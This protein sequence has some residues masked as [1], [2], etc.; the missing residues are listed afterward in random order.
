MTD[1]TDRPTDLDRPRGRNRVP[2]VA[3]IALGVVVLVVLAVVIVNNRDDTGSELPEE[4]A[5]LLD[6]YRDAWV[7]QDVETFYA[8]IT[9]DFFGREYF[10]GTD[11]HTLWKDWVDEAGTASGAARKLEFDDPLDLIEVRDVVV[12]GDGPWIVTAHEIWERGNDFRFRWDGNFTRVIVQDA[13][14]MKIA[15]VLFAGTITEA[16]N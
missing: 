1:A 6:D 5:Q 13:G 11:T 4:A 7:N 3:L 9:D 12:A 14:A 16:E 15:S 10:Y 8:S 2:T